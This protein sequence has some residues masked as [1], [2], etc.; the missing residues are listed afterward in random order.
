MPTQRAPPGFQETAGCLTARGI[1]GGEAPVSMDVPETSVAPI[2]LIEPV[3]T[4]VIST[5]MGQDKKWIL[6]MYRL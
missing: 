3:I 6:F 1:P 5:S 4:M 2:P